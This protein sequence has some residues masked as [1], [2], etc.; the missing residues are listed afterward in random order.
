MAGN[1]VSYTVSGM[2][3]DK[4]YPATYLAVGDPKNGTDPTYVSLTT[5]FTLSAT[6]GASGIDYIEYQFNSTSAWTRYTG[7]FKA[8]AKGSY[9]LYYHSV[10][11]A[12][13]SE[14][15]KSAAIVVVVD[16]Y[17]FSDGFESGDFTAWTG[18]VVVA[19]VTYA[20]SPA[21]KYTGTYSALATASSNGGY[22]MYYKTITA[23]NILYVRLYVKITAS[24]AV[25]AIFCLLENS[26]WGEH[27][28]FGVTSTRALYEE[29]YTSSWQTATSATTLST[30]TWYCIEFLFDKTNSQIKMWLDGSQ[31]NDLTKTG[32]SLVSTT[33]KVN[34]GLRGIRTSQ[35]WR[36]C[37][38]YIDCVAIDSSYIGPE[39]SGQNLTF[40]L[41]QTIT[42]TASPTQ[43]EA[44][45]FS[46]ALTIQPLTNLVFGKEF[47]F[48][49]SETVNPLTTLTQLKELAFALSNII[50][51]LAASV[52]TLEF[53]L[54]SKYCHSEIRTRL[55]LL[56]QLRAFATA[57][58][59]GST[60]LAAII[61]RA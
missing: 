54:W 5:I 38:T 3:I 9:T 18:K 40:T 11:K 60:S 29:W 12:A 47:R 51:A 50:T 23:A 46:Q 43:T 34:V 31:V 17:I 28:G 52:L 20:V 2:N 55:N 44:S 32:Q 59:T 24:P 14:P 53:I 45:R 36:T 41:S 1:N 21:D 25:T 42:P 10:D 7:S 61:G 26:G 8:P 4:T 35:M 48:I 37:T 15:A 49:L 56:K 58:V 22:N 57:V 33:D 39:S 6:D 19:G 16:P 30:N 13:N 27:T